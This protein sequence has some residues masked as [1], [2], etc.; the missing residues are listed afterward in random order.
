MEFSYIAYGLVIQSSLPLPELPIGN[1]NKDVIIRIESIDISRIEAIDIKKGI[2][3]T[4]EGTYFI[5]ENV[6]VFLI[7]RGSEIIIDPASGVEEETLRLF[8]LGQAM[9]VLLHQRGKF[10]LHGS[11]IAMKCGAIA[12]LGGEESGKSTLAAALYVHGHSVVV[13]DVIVVHIDND[14][15]IVFPGFPYLKLWPEVPIY[16]VDFL[17]TQPIL[18][19][20]LKIRAYPVNRRFSSKPLP[21]NRIY[22]LD[23]SEDKKIEPLG[24]QEAFMELVRHSYCAQ[25][26]SDG[27]ASLHFLQCANLVNHIP[28]FRLNRPRLLSILPEVV[29]MV[30]EDLAHD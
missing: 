10:I 5:Y 17:K 24:P 1:G 14:S 3:I 19:P 29:R 7:R 9:G 12:F 23:E 2:Q 26:L 18:Y 25:L 21:L 30:E 28:I 11:A 13:D 8:I 6:G 16:L 15:P 4:S 27:G 22:V 20:H